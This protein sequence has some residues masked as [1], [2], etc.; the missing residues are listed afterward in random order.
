MTHPR[1]PFAS[2]RC[3]WL[4]ELLACARN[5]RCASPWRGPHCTPDTMIQF[6]IL[7]QSAAS[8]AARSQLRAGYR[9]HHVVPLLLVRGTVLC[10]VMSRRAF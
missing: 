10:Q 5:S 2:P 4:R 1:A 6:A 8:K 7:V 3:G 9:G